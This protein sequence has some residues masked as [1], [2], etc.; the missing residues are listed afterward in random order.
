MEMKYLCEDIVSVLREKHS[1]NEH[2][3]SD[4]CTLHSDTMKITYDVRI[5]DGEG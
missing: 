2:S 5:G 1:V 3:L 4:R